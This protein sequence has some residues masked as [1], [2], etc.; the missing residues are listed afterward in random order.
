MADHNVVNIGT[1]D[2]SCGIVELSRID[3]DIGKVVYALASN[4]YHPSRGKAGA[5][6]LFSDLSEDTSNGSMLAK[7]LI[8]NFGGSINRHETVENPKTGNIIS[9]WLWT[10]P[11]E[12][13]KSWYV[14]ERVERVKQN[15]I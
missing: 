10:I 11:H 3:G 5:V 8:E 1:S 4:M 6:V 2:S 15:K 7:F 12:E 13:F 14:K 9:V